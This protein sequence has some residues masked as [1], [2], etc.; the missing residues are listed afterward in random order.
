MEPL[1]QKQWAVKQHR[2]QTHL[3]GIIESSR[4]VFLY[5]VTRSTANPNFT[6]TISIFSFQQSGLWTP[7]FLSRAPSPPRVIRHHGFTTPDPAVE[8]EEEKMP[9]DEKGLFLPPSDLGKYLMLGTNLVPGKL[10]FGAKNSTVWFF[11]VI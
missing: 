8:I 5:R 6:S 2:L 4:T 10:G 11:A 1:H 9:T 7:R 3:I